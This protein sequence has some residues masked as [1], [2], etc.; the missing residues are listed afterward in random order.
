[1]SKESDFTVEVTG[2]P[3]P[4]LNEYQRKWTGQIDTVDEKTSQ[5]GTKFWLF[6]ELPDDRGLSIVFAVFSST[7]KEILDYYMSSNKEFSLVYNKEAKFG[8]FNIEH[9]ELPNGTWTTKEAKTSWKKGNKAN[10]RALA[11]NSSAILYGSAESKTEID[12][13]KIIDLAEV[14]LAWIEIES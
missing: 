6:K 13:Q 8:S 4:E 1:M 10:N 7:D 5:R 11:L 2:A 14:F 3:L 9:I 12:P